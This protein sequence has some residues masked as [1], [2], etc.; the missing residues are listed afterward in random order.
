V[1]VY[2]DDKHI[3]RATSTTWSTTLKKMIAVAAID[4]PHYAAGTRVQLEVT[5]EAVR[6]TASA[7]VVKTPFFSPARKTATPPA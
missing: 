2:L 7:T 4:A 3:G 5:V 1:P 6:H